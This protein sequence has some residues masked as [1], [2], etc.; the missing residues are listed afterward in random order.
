M[1]ARGVVIAKAAQSGGNQKVL[2]VCKVCKGQRLVSKSTCYR[3]L[4]M[5]AESAED[6]VKRDASRWRPYMDASHMH[7]LRMYGIMHLA[8]MRLG[9]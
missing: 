3:H 2:C 8:S 6:H 7:A 4:R 1:K 9:F 5:E